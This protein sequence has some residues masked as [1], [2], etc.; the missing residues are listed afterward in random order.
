MMR[1]AIALSG[2]VTILS[3]AA[4]SLVVVPNGTSR[5][6]GG[7]ATFLIAGTDG[8]GVADCLTGGTECGTIVANAWCESQGFSRAESFGLAAPETVTGSAQVGLSR[9]SERPIAIT[10][11]N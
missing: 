7:E 8:Y 10:C 3:V 4:S 11:V 2:F 5:A 1:R 6:A 9:A